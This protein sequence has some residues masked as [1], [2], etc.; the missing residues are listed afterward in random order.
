MKTRYMMRLLREYE[1]RNALE[2]VIGPHVP[3]QHA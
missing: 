1:N 3:T 2:V